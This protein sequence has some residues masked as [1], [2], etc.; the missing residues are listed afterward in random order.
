[1]QSAQLI[2]ALLIAVAALVTVAR[3]LGIAYP[4]FLVIGGLALGLVPGTPRVQVDP[5]LIFLLVLPPLL[6]IASFYT[7]LRSLRANLGSVGS[8]AIGLVVATA[9]AAGAA[10]HALM[11]GM[12][13]A[14]AIALGAI[15]APPDAIAAPAIV[16][17]LEVPRRIVTILEGES[18]V[19]GAT[20]LTVYGIAIAVAGGGTFHPGAGALTF[21]GTL[22]GGVLVGLAVGFI[23]GEVRARLDDTPVEITLSLLTPYAAFLPAQQLGLSGVIAT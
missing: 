17:R 16:T 3:R 13:W 6:Y 18:L 14:V 12:S 10:A 20:A 4:I 23:V 9:L 22:A 7:P 5:D 19:D 2:L 11:P 1:M 21:A 15:V 8:L